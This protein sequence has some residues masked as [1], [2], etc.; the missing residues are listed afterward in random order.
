[1]ASRVTPMQKDILFL[2]LTRPPMILGVPFEGFCVNFLGSFFVGLWG[3]NPFYWL[4]GVFL[5]FPLQAIASQ[6]HNCFRIMR[7][8]IYTKG[9]SIGRE[10][11]GGS[12]LSP[13]PPVDP[14]DH[15]ARGSCV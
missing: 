5:H 13:L 6:D 8:W 2:A 14:D 10:M 11:W 12:M 4:I 15:K 9:S 7:L 3:S 1:M